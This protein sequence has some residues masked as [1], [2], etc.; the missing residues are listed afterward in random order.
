MPNLV[1][2]D[3]EEIN[4]RDG[5][6]LEIRID[7]Q[8]GTEVSPLPLQPLMSRILIS[9][10]LHGVLRRVEITQESSSGG[11]GEI[12]YRPCDWGWTTDMWVRNPVSDK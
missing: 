2:I 5:W 10:S 4:V 3:L 7:R 6:I 8:G 12:C 9:S 11:G 1:A